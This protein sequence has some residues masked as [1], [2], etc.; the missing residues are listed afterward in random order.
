MKTKKAFT[1]IELLVVISIIAL[2][3][4]I[5]MPALTK[6][7]EQAKTTICM[8]NQNSLGTFLMMYTTDNNDSFPMG[9]DS[10]GSGCPRDGS[11]NFAIGTYMDRD[12]SLDGSAYRDKSD[13]RACPSAPIK[14]NTIYS[15]GEGNRGWWTFW[16]SNP[17]NSLVHYGSYGFN[18]W[19][20][21][22]PQSWPC[23]GAGRDGYQSGGSIEWN[24]K[25]LST[26]K[27]AYNVPV[28]FDSW[29]SNAM[30]SDRDQPPQKSGQVYDGTSANQGMGMV[31]IDRHRNMSNNILFADMS[32]RKVGLKELW[33]LSW[34]R[35]FDTTTTYERWNTTGGWPDW[36]R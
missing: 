32:V 16:N 23:P 9:F 17:Q 18:R 7:R 26:T 5:L 22:C 19:M 6:V 24:W 27:S 2:L 14:D 4:A 36:M 10:T 28:L 29:Y 11:W 33:T 12:G 34:H 8:T 35:R 15:L 13:L 20:Y 1:L 3:M 31:C 21:D 30:P 25:K